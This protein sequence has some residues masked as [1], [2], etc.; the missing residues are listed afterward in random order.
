MFHIVVK[1][2]LK[3][4]VVRLSF[5]A[6][7]NLYETKSLSSLFLMITDVWKIT[8][9]YT[10][11]HVRRIPEEC[12]AWSSRGEEKKVGAKNECMHLALLQTHCCLG[13]PSFHGLD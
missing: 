10:W 9:N 7:P 5:V 2:L 13:L 12:S 6:Y 3:L 4:A 8:K 1:S 11:L